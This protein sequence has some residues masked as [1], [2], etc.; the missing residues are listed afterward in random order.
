MTE[1]LQS[2]KLILPG[3][4]LF[5]DT[6]GYILPPGEKCPFYIAKGEAQILHSATEAELEEYLLGGEWEHWQQRNVDQTE[7]K[8]IVF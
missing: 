7:E 4:P 2:P 3:D 1:H 8:I 5:E 6:L